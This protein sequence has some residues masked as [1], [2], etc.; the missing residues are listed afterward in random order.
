MGLDLRSPP[1]HG[2]PQPE[3]PA[4]GGAVSRPPYGRKD[5]RGAI[6]E[7]G[8]GLGAYRIFWALAN[9][10]IRARYRRSYFG[11]L[12]MTLASAVTILGLGFLWSRLW[13]IPEA[14][15]FPFLAAGMVTWTYIAAILTEAPNVFT[16]QQ[17]LLRNSTLSP[18][19]YP[20]R[21]AVKQLI[22]ALH[23]VPVIFVV[24]LVFGRDLPAT[25]PLFLVGFALIFINS[26]W[27][28]A[29]LGVIGAR[30]RDLSFTIEAAVPLA[31]FLTP[32]LWR[33]EDLGASSAI[34]RFNPFAYALETVRDPLLGEIPSLL[35][36]AVMIG[37]AV[38]GCAL[39]VWAFRYRHR[40]A[41]WVQ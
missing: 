13:G 11:P 6:L 21:S 14:D 2:S 32:V 1:P 15:Y 28:M 25:A 22:M 30:L 27:V 10:E 40:L 33:P 8:R 16:L 7:V 29:V 19:V 24:I 17:G 18:F 36:Y 37:A 4:P 9:S 34:L 3:A 12:W 35:S 23:Q 5:L 38:L 31:F 20:M 39:T 41:F 26:V